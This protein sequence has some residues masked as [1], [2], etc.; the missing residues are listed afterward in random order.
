MATKITNS[1]SANAQSNGWSFQYASALVIYLENMNNAEYFCLES[2]DDIIVGLKEGKIAA[3]AKS[4][5]EQDSIV[6]NHF[7]EISESIRT[8]SANDDANE[9]ISIFNFH[10]PLG[11]ND[12]FSHEQ[13]LDKKSFNNLTTETQRLLKEKAKSKGLT[14][15]FN[16]FK[17][18]FLRFEGDNRISS[19]EEFLRRKLDSC[20][21]SYGYSIN[22]LMNQWLQIIQSNAADKQKLVETSVMCGT[23]FGKILSHV[24]FDKIVNLI[25]EEIDP[26][27]EDDF[28]NLFISFL[29]KTHR[30]LEL[31]VKLLT[32][33]YRIAIGKNL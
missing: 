15:D 33:S 27:Y 22:D 8:L 29:V 16:K 24:S 18:W 7:K 1:S 6:A 21:L 20:N 30:T 23:L 19:I 2:T 12:S 13:L 28:Q 5:L 26:C 11:D 9:L 17:L 14:I 25:G 31:I 3:Q 4:G 32:N 10:K